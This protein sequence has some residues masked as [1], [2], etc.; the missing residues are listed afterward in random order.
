MAFS[1]NLHP[2]PLE[3]NR[4]EAAL[5]LQVANYIEW[6]VEQQPQTAAFVVTILGSSSISQELEKLAGI[7][8]VKGRK[9]EIHRAVDLNS[10]PN[11]D[12]V[13]V[14]IDYRDALSDIVKKIN[15][16]SVTLTDSNGSGKSAAMISFFVKDNHIR[17]RVNQTELKRKNFRVSSQLL[18]YAESV[19]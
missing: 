11:S 6:P 16:A 8:D 15:P 4:I 7:K 10:I 5:I 12:M 14:T 17:F 1:A 18:K 13:F 3:R 2:E 19:D 9:I